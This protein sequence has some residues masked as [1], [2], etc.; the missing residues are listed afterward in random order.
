MTALRLSAVTVVMM[1]APW[2]AS[3]VE[4]QHTTRRLVVADLGQAADPELVEAL[5]KASRQ[6]PMRSSL[7]DHR[8]T[9]EPAGLGGGVAARVP[10]ECVAEQRPAGPRQEYRRLA[11]DR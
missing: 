4:A 8:A 7:V 5:A 10:A 1:S 6:A 11:Q 2:H 9:R 3:C